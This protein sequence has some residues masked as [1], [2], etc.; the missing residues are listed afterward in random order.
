MHATAGLGGAL[1]AGVGCTDGPDQSS[2]PT[3]PPNDG[4]NSLSSIGLQLFTLVSPME[5]DFEG[6]LRRVAEVGYKELEFAGYFGRDP[7]AIRA[8]LDELQLT[9]PATHVPIEALRSDLAGVL[10]AAETIGHRY[11]VCPW[12]SEEERTSTKYLENAHFFTEVG[13][14]C[15]EQGMQFAYHNHDFE[16]FEIDGHM[17]FNILLDNTDDELVAF[18]MDLYWIA[19]GGQDALQYF[20][21]RP[22]RFP[23]WHVKDMAPDESITTVG[24]GT[25]DFASIFKERA[26][27]GLQHY[28]VEHDRPEDPFGTITRGFEH[29]AALTF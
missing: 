13:A 14:A 26:T 7:D 29:L 9:A 15:K 22:G 20:A 2:E 11:I 24:E 18:E 6:T 27:A 12:I 16:F 3:T 10:E 5:E 23:L 21:Q 17:P 4:S 8:L 28:F 19:K 1:L 25:I